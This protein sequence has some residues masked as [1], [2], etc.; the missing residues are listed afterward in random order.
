MLDYLYISDTKVDVIVD[1]IPVGLRDRIAAELKIDLKL[2]SLTVQEV[3]R[4][5]NRF[6]RARI[7]ADYV[8]R[9]QEVGTVDSPGPY[10]EGT[11]PMRWGVYPE[12]RLD[13]PVVYFAGFTR[14][15]IVGLGGSARHV[16]GSTQPT[17]GVSIFTLAGSALPSIV[18]LI[19]R[20]DQSPDPDED[21]NR[22]VL[23][24]ATTFAA[25]MAGPREDLQFLA[26]RLLA[27]QS[28]GMTVV[29]GSPLYVART[30]A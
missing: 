10:F 24:E 21:D 14:Q 6:A 27:G 13:D 28:G 8:I 30:T 17:A 18:Q 22:T 7:A 16:L 19:A 25:A 11:L 3:R 2:V 20:S 26:R 23:D 15:T 29:V 12:E 5:E 1:Q 9:N 4:P